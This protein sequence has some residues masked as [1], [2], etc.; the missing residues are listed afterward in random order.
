MFYV[1]WTAGQGKYENFDKFSK[2]LESLSFPF[3]DIIS[4][5]VISAEVGASALLL[6]GLFV[7]WASIPL[8]VIMMSV[9]FV[10]RQNGWSYENNG[11]EFAVIYGLM[12]LVLF[13]SG[14]GR[15]LSLDFWVKGQR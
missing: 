5:L 1:F 13:F 12:L 11:V 2:Y 6:V 9:Y 8:L 4:W 14:G 10:Q 15:Y 3:P 7:R